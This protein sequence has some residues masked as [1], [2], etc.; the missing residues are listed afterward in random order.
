PW[1][2]A[3]HSFPAGAPKLARCVT[4]RTDGLLVVRSAEDGR[5]RDQDRRAGADDALRGVRSDPAV[6]LDLRLQAALLDPA[7]QLLDLREARLDEALAAEAGVYGH[8]Q[9]HVGLVE[10]VFEVV[11]R[12]MRIEGDTGAG[13]R[14]LDLLQGAVEV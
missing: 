9:H 7:G 6:Y 8:H 1:R 11:G 3:L 5:T 2:R 10:H 14:R 4:K 12:R 13:P